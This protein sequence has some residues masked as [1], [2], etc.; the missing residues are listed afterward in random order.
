MSGPIRRLL[1]KSEP[2]FLLTQLVVLVLFAVLTAVAAIWSS[3][4]QLG[5]LTGHFI[6]P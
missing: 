3:T 4:E 6:N 1:R 5:S 2:P